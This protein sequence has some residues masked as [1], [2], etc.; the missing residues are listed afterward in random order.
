MHKKIIF[1]MALCFFGLTSLFA[2]TEEIAATGIGSSRDIAILNAVENAVRQFNGVSVS[3]TDPTQALTVTHQVAVDI[4]Q[5]DSKSENKQFTASGSSSSHV[6]L[7]QINARYEGKVDSYK[8]IK[9]TKTKEGYQVTITASF[10]TLDKYEQ[11]ALSSKKEYSLAVPV[12]FSKQS[13]LCAGNE[14]LALLDNATFDVK[15]QLSQTRRFKL[16]DRQNFAAYEEELSLVAAGMTQQEEMKR[17]QNVIPADYILIGK[18]RQFSFANEKETLDL[19]GETHTTTKGKL[20][21]EFSL[22]ETATMENVFTS[23]SAFSIDQEDSEL[24][25][26]EVFENLSKKVAWDITHKLSNRLFPAA[27]T[28]KTGRKV[29][30]RAP[31]PQPEPVKEV[32]R[33]VV[34]LPF[35]K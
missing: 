3:K 11:G 2:K 4:A 33:P 9:E 1:L 13:Q 23:R 35:D 8:V 22:L 25:C 34:K 15:E 18:I 24:T 29:V 28:Q 26:G 5:K 32:Q 31:D 6:I 10:K 19:L 7:E 14:T 12:F 30:R 27:K 20:E 21:M 16:L 17:L